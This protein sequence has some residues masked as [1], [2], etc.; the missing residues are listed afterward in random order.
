MP[1]GTSTARSGCYAG[2]R[3]KYFRYMP[4]IGGRRRPL[5]PATPAGA[6]EVSQVRAASS[7]IGSARRDEAGFAPCH[8]RAGR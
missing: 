3:V 8:S 4:V 5:G 1:A 2:N 6:G 7:S